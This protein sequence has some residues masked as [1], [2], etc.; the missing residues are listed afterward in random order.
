M[1]ITIVGNTA[2]GQKLTAAAQDG[3]T[4]L[5]AALFQEAEIVMTVSK[6]EYVPVDTGALRASGH[7]EPP[8]RTAHGGAVTLGY[9]GPS[10]PYAVIVHED[11]TKRHPVGGAKY[12]ELPLRARLQG[13]PVILGQKT[14]A[15]I[16]KAFSQFG[17]S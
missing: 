8:L 15:A 13:M 14:G 9:G 7:V 4:G 16:R 5:V 17:K 11:L 3:P 10:A 6:R 1:N 2:V 12:L